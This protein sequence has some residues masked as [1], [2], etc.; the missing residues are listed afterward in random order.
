MLSP[1]VRFPSLPGFSSRGQDRHRRGVVE[2]TR[3]PTGCRR[4]RGA[5]RPGTPP[6]DLVARELDGIPEKILANPATAPAA[7]YA[8]AD[9]LRGLFDRAAGK[10][11]S[12]FVL[13]RIL[14]MP[15]DPRKTPQGSPADEGGRLVIAGAG[16]VGKSRIALQLAASVISG[17]NSPQT[18]HVRP[19]NPL[20]PQAE[21][22]NVRLKSDL[23]ALRGMVGRRLVL[24]SIE[25]RI[26]LGA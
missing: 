24:R 5:N 23:G 13:W 21:N 17:G 7:A 15:V 8:A 9:A 11:V 19:R 4:D 6:L 3:A 25:A 10:K 20:A 26:H 1:A 2:R 18:H 12:L 16:G 22:D 14:A